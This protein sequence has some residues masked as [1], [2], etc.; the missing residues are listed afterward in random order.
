MTP[1]AR[2]PNTAARFVLCQ[3]LAH[4]H[5]LGEASV[6]A[7]D[8]GATATKKGPRSQDPGPKVGRP[9]A[10]RSWPRSA[11]RAPARPEEPAGRPR[12]HHPHGH[13]RPHLEKHGRDQVGPG[14]RRP[15]RGEPRRLRR[16]RPMMARSSA[17]RSRRPT[18][19]SPSWRSRPTPAV[20]WG[21]DPRL[22]Q[23]DLREGD[24]V[25]DPVSRLPGDRRGRHRDGGIDVGNHRDRRAGGLEM[26]TTVSVDDV[27][28]VKVGQEASPRTWATDRPD[29]WRS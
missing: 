22:R 1:E 24:L 3:H 23:L 26:T 29:R 19:T 28:K 9:P 27:T 13:R 17:P 2:V 8:P 12:R 11:H 6:R 25:G 4:L 18:T 20:W 10:G 15:G 5:P 21:R 16:S 14:R 7:L